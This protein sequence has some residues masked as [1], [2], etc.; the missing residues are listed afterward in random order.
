FSDKIPFNLGR[1]P[2]DIAIQKE[3]FSFYFPITTSILLSIVLSM[4]FYL[5]DKF[6]R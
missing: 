1:L 5:F 3:N 4:L 2:G 6:F